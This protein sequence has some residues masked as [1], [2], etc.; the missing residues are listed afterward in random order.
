[1]GL[2]GSVLV[3]GA[4]VAAAATGG[5]GYG[6]YH[7]DPDEDIQTYLPIGLATFGTVIGLILC[8]C[9][10]TVVSSAVVALFV[11]FAEDPAVLKKTHH[12]EFDMLVEAHPKFRNIG[13]NTSDYSDYGGGNESAPIKRVG[14]NSVSV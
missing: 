3:L 14:D 7:D 9:T 1:M 12:E 13:G 5:I 2:T 8:L 11:C 6:I 10:M 4:L